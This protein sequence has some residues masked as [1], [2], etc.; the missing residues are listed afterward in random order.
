MMQTNRRQLQKKQTRRSILEAAYRTFSRRGFTATTAEIAK[1]AGVAHGSVF[2][3]F[4]TLNSL[5][6]CL[7][8]EFGEAIGSRL[9]LLS[10]HQESIG[11]FLDAQLDILREFEGFYIRLVSESSLLPPEANMILAEIQ[12]TTAYH[13][14]Q[15]ADA[16][17]EAGHIKN[18]ASYM[19]FNIWLGLLHYYLQHRE[20]FA[21]E[22]SV[23]ERYGAELTT[24]YLALIQN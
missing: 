17:K 8:S 4:P 14:C 10:K 3:H 21:P 24:A 12:S 19:L 22:G 6:I 2:A 7:V 13:F 9:H 1:E 23:L 11:A 16:E 20:L 18:I 15:V 5:L